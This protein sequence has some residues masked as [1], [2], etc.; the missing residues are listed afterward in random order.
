[1][2]AALSQNEMEILDRHVATLTYHLSEIAAM[3]ESRLGETNEMAV[4]ARN[5]QKEFAR[6]A[7]RVRR[8]NTVTALRASGRSQTA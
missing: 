4:S 5:A 2:R 7:N 1:M 6:F 8:Q 3:L